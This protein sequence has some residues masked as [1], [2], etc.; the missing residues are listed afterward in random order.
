VK[1][2]TTWSA[3]TMVPLLDHTTPL[4]RPLFV[5]I[6]TTDGDSFETMAGMP[7]FVAGA[8]AALAVDPEELVDLVHPTTARAATTTTMIHPVT[9][10]AFMSFPPVA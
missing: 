1:P 4:P 8:A 10:R 9:R 7:P 2:V 5:M 6:V 3:V